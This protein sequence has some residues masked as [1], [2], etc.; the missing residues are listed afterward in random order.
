RLM[1]RGDFPAGDR[2]VA[3]VRN[4]AFDA[5]VSEADLALIGQAPTYER[6]RWHP[7]LVS[8]VLERYQLERETTGLFV[9]RRR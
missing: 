1:E 4:G 7:A 9:Y 5:V 6:Q 8:A 2:L 3:T